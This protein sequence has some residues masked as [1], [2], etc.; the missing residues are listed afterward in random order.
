[1]CISAL[2]LKLNGLISV[3]ILSKEKTNLAI[4]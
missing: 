1:L 2:D 3:G 4:L